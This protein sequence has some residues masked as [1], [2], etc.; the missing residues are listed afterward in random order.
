MAALV[1]GITVGSLNTAQRGPF[2]PDIADDLGQSV[3]VF[4][5]AAAAFLIV[6]ALGGLIIGPLA[7]HYGH[8]RVLILG[9]ALS[10][11]SAT[12]GGL[13]PNYAVLLV[14]RFIGGLGM[15]AT[16]G[17]VFAIASSRYS[18][19]VRLRA[20]S[21]LTGSFAL[22]GIIGIPLLT[23][24]SAWIDWR[25]AWMFVGMLGFI[26]M[27]VYVWLGPDDEHRSTDKL[28]LGAIIDAYRTLVGSRQMLL[29]L[30]GS[31]FQG[32]LFLAALTYNGAYFIDELGL[33]VQEFGIVAAVSSAAFAAGSFLAGRVPHVDLRFLFGLTMVLAGL[34][35]APAYFNLTGPIITTVFISVSFLLA[36]I[37]AV[38]LLDLLAQHTPAGQATTLVLNESLFSLG[39][40][41]G[42]AAGG[43]AISVGGFSALAMLLPV[44]GIVGGFLVWR[45]ALV[46]SP[47][48]RV[49]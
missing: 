34:L 27:L 24:L 8:R 5:Q 38:A 40:A 45:P 17:I 9:L 39:A 48:A 15:A 44:L 47:A 2:I 18:G 21:I 31:A 26:A 19:A 16:I 41:I 1:V 12:T 43:I 35:L 3:A 49:K 42:A 20:L 7:D 13:A 4:G 29:L 36:G 25:G 28:A 14:T 6:A 22:I 46:S 30:G 23:G 10:A 37:G 33:S 11:I 32:A